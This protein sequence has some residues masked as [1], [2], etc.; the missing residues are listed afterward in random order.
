V[1]RF[2]LKV[3]LAPCLSPGH[4]QAVRP[5]PYPR[6]DGSKPIVIVTK[7]GGELSRASLQGAPLEA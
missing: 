4:R 1:S 3:G 6:A 7:S 2:T 5:A